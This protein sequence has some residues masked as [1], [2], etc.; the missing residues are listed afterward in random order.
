M[1]MIELD[2]LILNGNK[3]FWNICYTYIAGVCDIIHLNPSTMYPELYRVI[4][5]Q[6]HYEWM[7]P[8]GLG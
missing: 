4:H 8:L 6:C 2:I 7:V 1:A 5:I 3:A